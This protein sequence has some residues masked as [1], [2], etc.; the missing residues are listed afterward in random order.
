MR[1]GKREGSGGTIATLRPCAP[2]FSR[3]SRLSRLGANFG[4]ALASF[5]AV[6]RVMAGSDGAV[7]CV[8]RLALRDLR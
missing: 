8:V 7:A 3:L 2:L 5:G 1:G 4:V 6:W